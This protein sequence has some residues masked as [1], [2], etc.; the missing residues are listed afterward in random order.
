MSET[1]PDMNQ[2]EQ[3]ACT[4]QLLADANLKVA[5]AN[6]NAVQVA[7]AGFTAGAAVIGAVVALMK[8]VGH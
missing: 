4:M 3:I 2:A 7:F 5:Q 1:T 6:T 8:V